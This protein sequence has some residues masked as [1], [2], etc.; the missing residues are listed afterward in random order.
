[1]SRVY[2]FLDESG[3]PY[4]GNKPGR[5]CDCPWQPKAIRVR[6]TSFKIIALRRL[7]AEIRESKRQQLEDRRNGR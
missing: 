5:W 2:E 4:D 3:K 7:A 1:M 6:L